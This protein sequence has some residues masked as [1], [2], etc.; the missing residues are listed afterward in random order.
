M[1]KITKDFA[2]DFYQA[3]ESFKFLPF[4]TQIVD[5][6][7]K[8]PVSSSLREKYQQKFVASNDFDVDVHRE[9]RGSMPPEL[10]PVALSLCSWPELQ[11]A[12]DLFAAYNVGME[13]G[14]HWIKIVYQD[15]A[16]VYWFL[17]NVDNSATINIRSMRVKTSEAIVETDNGVILVVRRSL[18]CFFVFAGNE[19]AWHSVLPH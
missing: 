4:L 12:K 3:C 1:R 7:A 15:D 18:V 13:T 19:V 8:N 9:P 11:Q 17:S 2:S 16:V 5:N 14:T 10:S 6:A